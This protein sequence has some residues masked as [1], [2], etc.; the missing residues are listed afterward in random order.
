MAPQRLAGPVS[1]LPPSATP[2]SRAPSRV[3]PNFAARPLL[4]QLRQPLHDAFGSFRLSRIWLLTRR[5]PASPNQQRIHELD[6][7][8]FPR[9]MRKIDTENAKYV[10][11]WTYFFLT[12]TE[13]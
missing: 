9:F 12:Y 4:L 13:Y 1:L 6:V 11:M 2:K 3:W 10:S 5:G 7:P 8:I